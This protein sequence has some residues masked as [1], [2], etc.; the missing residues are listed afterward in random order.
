MDKNWYWKPGAWNVLCP[1]CGFKFK[2]DELKLRWDG[3]MVCEADWEP[4]HPQD[5]FRVDPK[6]KSIPW[7][8]PDTVSF[9]HYD[10]ITFA[11][12][13]YTMEDEISSLSVDASGG[14]LTIVL[15]LANSRSTNPA[16]YLQL[17]TTATATAYTS[18]TATT[19]VAGDLD[20]RAKVQHL[21]PVGVAT[22]IAYAA[23][24][25]GLF[26]YWLSITSDGAIKLSYT[27]FGGSSLS[28]SST[29]SLTTRFSAGDTF[30]IRAT[31]TT[32]LAG[33]ANFYTSTDGSTWTSLG[34]ELDAVSLPASFTPNPI[35]TGL[36][37]DD[38]S[39]WVNGK[40]YYLEV[41]N[42]VNGTPVVVFDPTQAT[43]NAD[44]LVGTYNTWTITET[45]G[46]RL[47]SA[48]GFHS[49]GYVI[50]ISRID[51]SSNTVTIERS[52][53]DT[54]DGATS[55][56]LSG[57]NRIRLLSNDVDRWTRQNG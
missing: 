16:Q 45:F 4:R 5:L 46:A 13:P 36:S 28:A 54:I 12:T 31:K 8:K 3:E 18:G 24:V 10:S 6:E 53:T 11:D 33:K 21:F 44:T 7:S 50:N 43:V 47:T 38:S 52:G 49:G 17:P 25:G 48:L 23:A 39:S 9:N 42:G 55:I 20:I 26:P 34:V 40:L 2:S 51:T 1:V 57:A 35:Y 19:H 30:W 29:L 22:S 15:P 32:G 41:R 14:S 37:P 56:T 27:I